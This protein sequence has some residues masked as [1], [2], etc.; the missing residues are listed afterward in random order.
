MGRPAATQPA[1]RIN[2]H[3]YPEIAA[4]LKLACADTSFGGVRYGEQ[5]RI[6]NE[7]LRMYFQGVPACT[8]PKQSPE[9]TN[10]EPSPNSES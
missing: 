6:V 7:A 5:T 2:L 10:S 1:V 3:L 8:P 9:S 4:Q